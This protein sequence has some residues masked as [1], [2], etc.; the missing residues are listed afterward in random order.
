RRERSEHAMSCLQPLTLDGVAKLGVPA[1]SAGGRSSKSGATSRASERIPLCWTEQ[2]CF[3]RNLCLHFIASLN[4]DLLQS[5]LIVTLFVVEHYSKGADRLAGSILQ[6]QF[7]LKVVAFLV[8]L[9][10]ALAS[11]NAPHVVLV[12]DLADAAE[13]G[14]HDEV[15]VPGRS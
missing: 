10:V 12:P 14:S 1:A 4:C 15:L 3:R 8:E 2:S 9:K 11:P 5:F 6:D 7:I 13:V